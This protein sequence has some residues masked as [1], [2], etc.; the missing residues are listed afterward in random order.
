M[1]DFRDEI[2]IFSTTTITN[3]G[4][5]PHE[6]SRPS[7][8][9]RLD[10]VRWNVERLEWA[11]CVW[12]VLV[13]RIALGL[14]TFPRERGI[15]GPVRL[16]TLTLALSHRGRGDIEVLPEGVLGVGGVVSHV[17]G[18]AFQLG[19]RSWHVEG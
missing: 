18:E 8:A 7:L 1:T 4:N 3:Y 11:W 5:I 9:V 17:A 16:V 6:L 19:F 10:V 2:L 12:S 13:L 15:L 14:R